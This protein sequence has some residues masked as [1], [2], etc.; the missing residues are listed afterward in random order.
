MFQYEKSCFKTL[1]HT[2]FPIQGSQ[3]RHLLTSH[4]AQ[5]PVKQETT[6]RNP[7]SLLEIPLEFG[8][9]L[10]S[11]FYPENSLPP[12][13]KAQYHSPGSKGGTV[14]AQSTPDL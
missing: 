2:L 11:N 8:L 14:E 13:R 12:T 7:F 6:L 5:T 10:D 3:L 1:G 4:A 9:M